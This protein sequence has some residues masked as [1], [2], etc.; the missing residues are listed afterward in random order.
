[1]PLK[2]DNENIRAF[3]SALSI[4]PQQSRQMDTLARARRLVLKK[5]S[6][7]ARHMNVSVF[8]KGTVGTRRLR[9]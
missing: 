5:R 1:M 3:C 9:R 8:R 2:K 6:R 4:M 7:V